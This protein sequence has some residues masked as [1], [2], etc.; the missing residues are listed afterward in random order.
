MGDGLDTTTTKLLSV[1]F[2]NGQSKYV[3]FVLKHHSHLSD[4][5]FYT[6]SFIY[7]DWTSLFFYIA[8]NREF[9]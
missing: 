3:P 2:A 4:V 1:L 6:I 7:L 5:K 8:L 9:A